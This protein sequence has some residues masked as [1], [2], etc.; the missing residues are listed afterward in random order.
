MKKIFLSLI[1]FLLL[2]ITALANGDDGHM[3]EDWDHMMNFS[4]M[5]FGWF[6]GFF[7]IFF[8]VLIIFGVIALI[9]WTADQNREKDK[10]SDSA[11]EI[12]RKRYAKGK[13]SKEEFDEKKKHLS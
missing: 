6:G 10:K 3:M 2:P 5:P 4:F 1:I 13:I 12:L 8:W 11:L 7:M 9:K